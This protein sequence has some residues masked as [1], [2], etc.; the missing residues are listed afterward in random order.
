MKTNEQVNPESIEDDF[1]KA[2]TALN[3]HHAQLL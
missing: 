2:C 3:A 1:L